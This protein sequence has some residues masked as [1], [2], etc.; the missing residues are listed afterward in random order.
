MA[1]VVP[2]NSDIVQAGEGLV[3]LYGVYN[4]SVIRSGFRC[5]FAGGHRGGLSVES[6][7]QRWANSFLFGGDSGRFAVVEG[8]VLRLLGHGQFDHR[9]Q[10]TC[11]AV[12]SV[13][14][15]A[16]IRIEFWSILV[17]EA[18][19]G[20]ASVALVYV[21]TRRYFGIGRAF[22]LGL[23]LAVTPVAAMMFPVQQPEA[24]LILLMV[25]SVVALLRGWRTAG[26]D[27]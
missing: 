6:V 7:D 22:S 2:E 9:G 27:G 20:V 25:A 21:I 10:A 26:G 5:C 18:L 24:L 19:M 14:V 12:D 8:V 17:P 16:G 1:E 4:R 13:V 23:V 15:G 3:R 11:I